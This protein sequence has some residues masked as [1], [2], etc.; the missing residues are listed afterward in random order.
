MR[1]SENTQTKTPPV[2]WLC[3]HYLRI[4]VSSKKKPV[5]RGGKK[6][7]KRA[8]ISGLLV[9]VRQKVEER[10]K[11]YNNKKC[12]MEKEKWNHRTG[13]EGGCNH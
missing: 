9:H 3:D 13:K 6:Q 1:D 5:W 7:L 4:R 8:Q 2:C 11:D 10:G 12:N